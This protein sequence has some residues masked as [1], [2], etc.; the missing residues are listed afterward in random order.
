MAPEF[1]FRA[2]DLQ[3]I[4][5][6][7]QPE[8]VPA[9]HVAQPGEV[10]GAGWPHHSCRSL[11]QVEEADDWLRHGNPWEKARPEYMLPVHFYGRVEHTATGT[12]WVDT[13]VRAGAQPRGASMWGPL[14]WLVPSPGGLHPW[15][16]SRSIPAGEGCT[17]EGAS[18]GW[19]RR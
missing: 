11:R 4:S 3:S 16:G 8:P 1:R 2:D 7:M 6:L 17:G 5:P 12:K 18:L 14:A 15:R 10:P 19:K 13:Q 9:P